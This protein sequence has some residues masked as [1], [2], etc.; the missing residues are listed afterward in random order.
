[1]GT[2]FEPLEPALTDRHADCS[3]TTER[4]L[5]ARWSMGIVKFEEPLEDVLIA[6]DDFQ[7]VIAET[8]A[9]ED[10]GVV[11]VRFTPWSEESNDRRYLCQVDAEPVGDP[12]SGSRWMCWSTL[13]ETADELRA[14]L[15]K[16]LDQSRAQAALAVEAL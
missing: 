14:E 7:S 10:V 12:A 11:Q 1:M 6:S 5:R 15:R 16:A 3:T 8:L 13:F 4:F 9:G 2:A